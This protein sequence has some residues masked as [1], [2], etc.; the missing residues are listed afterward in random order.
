MKYFFFRVWESGDNS[1]HFSA[2]NIYTYKIHI[3]DKKAKKKRMI[4]LHWQPI[5]QEL[6]KGKFYNAGRRKTHRHRTRT[7]KNQ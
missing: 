2:Y 6:F 1:S 5:Y 4:M 7:K 3:F